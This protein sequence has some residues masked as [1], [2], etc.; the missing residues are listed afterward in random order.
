M[1]CKKPFMFRTVELDTSGLKSGIDISLVTQQLGPSSMAVSQNAK[2]SRVRHNC[3]DSHADKGDHISQKREGRSGLWI[4]K[5][6]FR[7]QPNRVRSS[8]TDYDYTFKQLLW[9]VK[10]LATASIK[11]TSW[12]CLLLPRAIL[13]TQSCCTSDSR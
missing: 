3:K 11:S 4:S 10:A 8:D 7:Q 13:K 2:A 5:R 9:P 1:R 6:C 12:P